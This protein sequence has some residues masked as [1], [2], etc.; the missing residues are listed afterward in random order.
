MAHPSTYRFYLD[1]KNREQ[2]PIAKDLLA[3]WVSGG[4]Y[5][6]QSPPA[7]DYICVDNHTCCFFQG[8]KDGFYTKSL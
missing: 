1:S 7:C 5:T 2:G 8:K 4:T 3:S 6:N